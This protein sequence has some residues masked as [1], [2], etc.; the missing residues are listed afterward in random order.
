MIYLDNAATTGIKPP[1]VIKAVGR[2]LKEFSV[3]PGRGGY[4]RAVKC[5]E[6]IY[7]CRDKLSSFFGADA[8]ERVIFTSGCT[9]SLNTVIKGIVRPGD[10]I[11]ISSLEHNSVVRPAYK[12]K[13]MGAELDVAEVYSE[14]KMQPYVLLKD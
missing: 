3:N 1:E 5:S 14:I 9:A 11:V 6:E 8:P 12:L 10:H 13:N 2:S 7:R 4:E